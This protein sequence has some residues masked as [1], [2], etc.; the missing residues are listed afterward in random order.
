M[1]YF[2][3]AATAFSQKRYSLCMSLPRT[4]VRQSISILFRGRGCAFSL[5][6][7]SG[8]VRRAVGL[9]IDSVAKRTQNHF[10]R[11]LAWR[12]REV[13]SFAR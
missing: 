12:A 1:E 5:Y 3:S 7:E 13:S 2:R 6:C 4:F 8:A 11:S 9:K 10:G